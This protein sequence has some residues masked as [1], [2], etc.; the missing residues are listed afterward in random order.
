[1]LS[2]SS[3][4]FKLNC[5]SCIG[6]THNDLNQYPVFPWILKDFSHCANDES[7]KDELLQ[8]ILGHSDNSLIDK[9]FRDLR[10]PIGALEPCR[11]EQILERYKTFEDSSGNIKP[12]HY[13]SHYSNAGIVLFY[14]MRLEPFA[15]LH[16]ELQAGR[17]DYPDRLFSSMAHTWKSCITS[18]SCFKELVPE[19][20]Y[21]P[22]CLENINGYNLGEKQDGTMVCK[23]VRSCTKIVTGDAVRLAEHVII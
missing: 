9:Y 3:R 8:A 2:Q 15:S 21:L 19:L 20:F 22:E 4:N 6:R 1:M 10:K 13:G 5:F 16:I 23:S 18:L 12:F 14:L 17:F 11:L 7:C